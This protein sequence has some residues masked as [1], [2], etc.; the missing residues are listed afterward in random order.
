MSDHP[1]I[2]IILEM[3]AEHRKDFKE[4][5]DRLTEDYRKYQHV[6]PLDQNGI[7]K[8]R[9]LPGG[10]PIW[11]ARMMMVGAELGLEFLLMQIRKRFS[12]PDCPANPSSADDCSPSPETH[13][14]SESDPPG[15]P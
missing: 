13:P 8:V 9:E 6:G 3:I 2:E 5:V 7:G 1:D 14:V 4:R 11:G 12:I 10:A 15:L